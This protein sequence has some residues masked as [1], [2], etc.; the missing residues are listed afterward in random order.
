MAANKAERTVLREKPIKRKR[1]G[2][3]DSAADLLKQLWQSKQPREARDLKAPVSSGNK[4]IAER[5]SQV[6]AIESELKSRKQEYQAIS[7]IRKR[8]VCLIIALSTKHSNQRTCLN[9]LDGKDALEGSGDC[10]LPK[11]L[12]FAFEH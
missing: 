7:R 8:N 2:I 4:R 10:C 9:S 3:H 6:D 12:N 5:Q 11:L 1:W